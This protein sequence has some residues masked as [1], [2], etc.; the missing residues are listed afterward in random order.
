[1][2]VVSSGSVIFNVSVVLFRWHTILVQEFMCVKFNLSS[3][4]LFSYNKWF[5]LLNSIT[6]MIS[7]SS[8]KSNLCMPQRCPR[9]GWIH[10]SGRVGLGRVTILPEFGGSGSSQHFGFFSFLLIISWGLNR[11]E[12]SNTLFRLIDSLQYLIL[13]KKNLSVWKK[14]YIDSTAQKKSNK[15]TKLLIDAFLWVSKPH[16]IKMHWSRI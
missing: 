7:Y 1:M 14:E 12:S 15:I 8:W 2:S 4:R 3:G 13:N 5:N 10:G 11:C 6:F 9:V 16:S